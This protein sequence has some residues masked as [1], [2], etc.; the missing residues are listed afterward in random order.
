MW[1]ELQACPPSKQFRVD[2]NADVGEECGQDAALMR[3]I[4]SANIACGGHAGSA[5]SMRETIHL[6]R[7]HRVA[8]GAHPS[9]ADREHFGRRET[10][11][12]AA[13]ITDLVIS[14][15]DALAIIAS[16]EGIR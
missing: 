9:F 14:Q 15:I 2:L 4:T 1:Q 16:Q 10:E 13:Q 3:C 6:A 11:L 12:P 5:A 8:V 7:R